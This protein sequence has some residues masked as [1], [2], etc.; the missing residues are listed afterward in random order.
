MICLAVK[1][2]LGGRPAEERGAR[3]ETSVKLL[4]D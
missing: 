3:I 2:A 1:E 4:S